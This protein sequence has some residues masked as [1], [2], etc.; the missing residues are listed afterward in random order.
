MFVKTP[1][2]GNYFKRQ[3]S[4]A[5]KPET[6]RGPYYLQMMAA[7]KTVLNALLCAFFLM[8]FLSPDLQ[9]SASV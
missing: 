9:P 8:Q 2:I 6:G 3:S 5:I 4:V 7:L 1:R